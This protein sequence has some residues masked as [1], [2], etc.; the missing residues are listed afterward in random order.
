MKPYNCFPVMNSGLRYFFISTGHDLVIHAR[1]DSQFSLHLPEDVHKN[2]SPRPNRFLR[3]N[4]TSIFA[5]HVGIVLCS[6]QCFDD[7]VRHFVPYTYHHLEE[8][9]SL[10]D[11]RSVHG[12]PVPDCGISAALVSAGGGRMGRVRFC[13]RRPLFRPPPVESFVVA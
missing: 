10:R 3:N 6:T 5:A 9:T 11:R 1:N 8:L 12:S 13:R 4:E 2:V 7:I